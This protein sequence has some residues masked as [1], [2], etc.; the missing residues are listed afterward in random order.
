MNFQKNE[1]ALQHL[2]I[3][4]LYGDLSE[5]DV[6]RFEEELKSNSLLKRILEDERRFDSAFPQITQP[7]ITEER[8]QGNRWLLH[9]NLQKEQRGSFSLKRWFSALAERP[10]AVAFQSAAMAMTFVLGVF[11]ASNSVEKST[12]PVTSPQLVAEASPLDLINDDDYEIY[13]LKVN[14]Y[15]SNTGEIDLSFSLASETSIRGNV[16]DEQIHSLMAVALQGDIGTASRLDT[17]NALQAVTSGDEVS[18]ALMYVLANDQ[19]PGVRYQAAQSL[20][21]L[22]HEES[23]RNALRYALLKDANQGVRVE[24]F[25]AL[26]NYPEEET[27]QVFRRQMDVDSNEFIR[28]ESRAIL[29][30][31]AETEESSEALFENADNNVI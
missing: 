21:A 3:R 1:E 11:V 14:N 6:V 30:R 29:Q 31:L 4:Y 7:L 12:V 26:V 19:N 24:A 23:V 16:A 13:Q 22:A 9:Q 28:S 15:D 10:F 5:G 2:V 20:A 25:Q 18:D 27:L 8:I 17:I